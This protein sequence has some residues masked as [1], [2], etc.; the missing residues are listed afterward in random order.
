MDSTTTAE[1]NEKIPTT[2][3]QD[4]FHRRNKKVKTGMGERSQGRGSEMRKKGMKI[5]SIMVGMIAKKQP[6]RRR[7]GG[8]Q[9]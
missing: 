3:E 5:C 2:K 8:Y 1:V 9:R 6:L 7:L 4:N